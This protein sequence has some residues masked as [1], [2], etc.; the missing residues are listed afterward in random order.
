MILQDG[1]SQPLA[2]CKSTHHCSDLAALPEWP[3]LISS[4]LSL[5]R[6]CACSWT[7]LCYI[8]KRPSQQ[9]E[10]LGY[11]QRIRELPQVPKRY[12]PIQD[13]AHRPSDRLSIHAGLP[14]I[15]RCLRTLSSS[16]ASGNSRLEL[17]GQRETLRHYD[18]AHI[19]RVL[20]K[21][22]SG[23]VDWS[24]HSQSAEIIAS[25]RSQIATSVPVAA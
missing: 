25:R 8:T 19:E 22:A 23:T 17:R 20:A 11:V 3:A 10:Y 2:A 13:A 24:S 16:M 6:S 7:L 21:Y 14:S 5:V 12:S 9:A 15:Q 18:I 4:I 1:S